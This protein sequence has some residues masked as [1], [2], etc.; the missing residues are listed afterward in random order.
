MVK[1]LHII[2]EKKL[3]YRIRVHKDAE[4]FGALYDHYVEKI[5]R[6]V[7][8]KVSHEEE[9]EDIVSEVFLKAWNYLTDVQRDTDTDIK[10][11]SGLIYTIART[12]LIDFFRARAKRKECTIEVLEM[13][14]HDEDMERAYDQRREIEQI[15]T[16]LKKMKRE[17]QEVIVLRYIEELSLKEIATILGKSSTATR[18]LLH[19]AMKV[20]EKSIPSNRKKS[21]K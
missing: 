3:L 16:Q 9:A 4:A 15:L 7:Y 1:G 5:Y 14:A 21:V 18:V 2:Q 19:R 13:V 12:S 6:F 8:F 10:S 17:Y 11:F 20:L